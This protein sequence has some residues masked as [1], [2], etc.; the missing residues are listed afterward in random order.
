[1]YLFLLENVGRED[2]VFAASL[3]KLY[4]SRRRALLWA[5][6][7]SRQR[8]TTLFRAPWQIHGFMIYGEKTYQEYHCYKTE[9]CTTSAR[10]VRSTVCT[11]HSFPIVPFAPS[12]QQKFMVFFVR[13]HMQR[14]LSRRWR[15]GRERIY[16][17]EWW[18]GDRRWRYCS[19]ALWFNSIRNATLPRQHIILLS[20]VRVLVNAIAYIGDRTERSS[21]SSSHH[22]LCSPGTFQSSG[23]KRHHCRGCLR[24]C[25]FSVQVP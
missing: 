18:A 6:N 12:W 21:L 9:A 3:P 20:S 10:V 8:D 4:I 22:S 15:R 1:M 17:G 25:S 7:E 11:V 14:K 2:G 13:N 23:T 16:H 24:N 19:T 5:L